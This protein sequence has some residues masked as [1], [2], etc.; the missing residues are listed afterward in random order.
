MDQ[1]KTWTSSCDVLSSL[2]SSHGT[3][4]IDSLEF[5][6]DNYDWPSVE[7]SI[8]KCKNEIHAVPNELDWTIFELDALEFSDRNPN[9]PERLSID[10]KVAKRKDDAEFQGSNPLH[11]HSISQVREDE[12]ENS[13]D[14]E[15]VDHYG[16]EVTNF[17]EHIES[18]WMYPLFKKQILSSSFSHLTFMTSYQTQRIAIE[19]LTETSSSDQLEHK[20][21]KSSELSRKNSQSLQIGDRYFT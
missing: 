12:N 1:Q 19:A 10:A 21:K 7:Q 5:S 13:G 18:T 6:I 17:E 16:L 11:E 9:S 8:C 14:W 3:V 2:V 15:I 4:F 20:M